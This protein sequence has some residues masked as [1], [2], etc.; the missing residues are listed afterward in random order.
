MGEEGKKV[1]PASTAAA[2]AAAALSANPTKGPVITT[3]PAPAI[4]GRS[5]PT[6]W[7]FVELWYRSRDFFI[8]FVEHAVAFGLLL[9]S[10]EIFHRILDQTSL[11]THDKGLLA[12]FHF[13]SYFVILVLF[14]ISFFIQ[15]ALKL[16]VELFEDELR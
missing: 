2:A 9:L 15:M 16:W 6:D 13:Y 14:G 1:A 12:R 4:A 10:L 8:G 5:R 7:W 3:Q 11:D